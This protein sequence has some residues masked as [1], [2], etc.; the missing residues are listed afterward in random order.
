MY[1]PIFFWLLACDATVVVAVSVGLMK[2]VIKIRLHV[3][4]RKKKF[5]IHLIFFKME[6]SHE[7]EV[8]KDV[9]SKKI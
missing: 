1:L 4:M 3:A 7:E 9:F 8:G 5:A 6:K 2:T